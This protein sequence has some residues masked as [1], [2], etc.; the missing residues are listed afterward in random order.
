[1]D[2][3]TYYVKGS[4]ISDQI[5][6]VGRAIQYR[7]LHLCTKLKANSENL[8]PGSSYNFP[9]FLYLLTLPTCGASF[10]ESKITV[11][12]FVAPNRQLITPDQM[13]ESM[14]RRPR[15]DPII[16][17]NSLQLP[18]RTSTFSAMFQLKR[19]EEMALSC[20]RRGSNQILEFFFTERVVRLWDK[21]PREVTHSLLKCSTSA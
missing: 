20:T 16:L 19:Q 18:K 12:Y 13:L 15:R 21:L 9:A 6:R 8:M 2:W 4:L 5:F 11:I 7:T 17:Y 1:M 3:S 14:K 10:F